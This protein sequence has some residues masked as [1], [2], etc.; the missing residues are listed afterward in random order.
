MTESETMPE[1][2]S[3]QPQP[4]AAS[5]TSL[6]GHEESVDPKYMQPSSPIV[7]MLSIRFPEQSP[8]IG[9]TGAKLPAIEVSSTWYHLLHPVKN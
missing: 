1:P 3:A 2:V 6:A 9:P 5:F 7:L 8:T 4:K